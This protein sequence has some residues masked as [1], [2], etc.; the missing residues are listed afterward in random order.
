MAETGKIA[1]FFTG[2]TIG[3]KNNNGTVSV[4]ESGTYALIEA[5]GSLPNKRDVQFE[6]AQ[7]L[8]VLSEN[9]VPDDWNVLMEALDG[10]D[11][12]EYAGIIV[13][14]G[15]DTLAYS[16]AMLSYLCCDTPVPIVLVAAN[17]HL[18]DER[19]NGVSNFAAAIDLIM[20]TDG[21]PGVFVVYRNDRNESLVYLGTR[22]TQ[23]ESFTDQFGSPYDLPYGRVEQGR[24]I[25]EAHPDNPTMEALRAR[26]RSYSPWGKRGS[27]KRVES[28][29]LYIKPFT[30][31]DYSFYDF[32]RRKP[33]AV[34]HDLY[35]S[36]TASANAPGNH[37]L[38]QF[39]QYCWEQG[40]DLYL[41]P[42]KDRTEAMYTSSVS[43]MEAGVVFIDNLSV[44]AALTK[45][46]LAYSLFDSKEDIESF[47]WNTELFYERLKPDKKGADRK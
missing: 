18:E 36:G 6:T 33:K 24:F 43:L 12:T 30:G 9:L 35:H 45:L 7:P 39:A 44:E 32:S 47:M 34:L 19:S 46:T 10:I 2:G 42:L 27:G 4:H 20:S 29:L 28:G 16:A 40:V 37:S 41:C 5:Y 31:I 11:K 22:I 1:V 13:T 38:L 21:A 23:C 15:S 8:N 3:S 14:H 17:Y 25:T 26:E